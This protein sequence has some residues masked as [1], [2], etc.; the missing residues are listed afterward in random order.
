MYF[1]GF[2]ISPHI[3]FNCIFCRI[4]ALYKKIKKYPGS[5]ATKF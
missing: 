5:L 1:L 3:S 4:I 2:K